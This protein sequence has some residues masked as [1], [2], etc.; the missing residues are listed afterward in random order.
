MFLAIAAGLTALGSAGCALFG[1]RETEAPEAR[2]PSWLGR[3]VMVD[4]VHGFALVDTGAGSA[5]A[6]GTAVLTLRDKRR[7]ALLRVTSEAQ[8][9]YVAMEIVDGSPELGDQAV[10]D[11]SGESP[12]APQGE[13]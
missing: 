3:V 6:A 11:E 5:P 10:M 7:T 8:P 4:A 12:P 13:S 9:P 2:L 1:P